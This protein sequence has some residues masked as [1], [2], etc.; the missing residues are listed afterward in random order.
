MQDLIPFLCGQMIFQTLQQ[1]QPDQTKLFTV[2]EFGYLGQRDNHYCD[3]LVSYS[4][5]LIVLS[6]L[7]NNQL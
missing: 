4:L 6:V 2:I 1:R 5:L 3:V 7:A